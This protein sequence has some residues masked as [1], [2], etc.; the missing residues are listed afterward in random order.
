V[1][2]SMRIE[3]PDHRIMYLPCGPSGTVTK[4][5]KYQPTRAEVLAFVKAAAKKAAKKAAK[6]LMAEQ[7]KAAKKAAKAAAKSRPVRKSAQMSSDIGSIFAEVE[8]TRSALNLLDAQRRFEAARGSV[9]KGAA[10]QALTLLR[11]KARAEGRI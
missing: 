8:A 6:L 7:E 5:A 9:E 2:N 4:S 1:P 11:L 10:G 3:L